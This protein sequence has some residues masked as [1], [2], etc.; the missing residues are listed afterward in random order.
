MK[1]RERFSINYFLLLVLFLLLMQMLFFPDVPGKRELSYHTFLKNVDEGKISRVVIFED[2]IVG[3][4]KQDSVSAHR[5]LT[6]A[7]AAPWRW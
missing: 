1:K 4:Y 3:E 6:D 2:K 7:P 5:A